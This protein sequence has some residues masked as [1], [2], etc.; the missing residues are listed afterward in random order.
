M[1]IKIV[2]NWR[3]LQQVKAHEISVKI[4]LGINVELGNIGQSTVGRI[5]FPETARNIEEFS[6]DVQGVTSV[7]VGLVPSESGDL[8][9]TA[10]RT[11]NCVF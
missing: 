11:G 6:C 2:W 7:V 10:V 9:Q 3:G 4:R 1:P 8:S 5:N